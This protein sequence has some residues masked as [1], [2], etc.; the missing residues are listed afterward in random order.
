VEVLRSTA[1][2]RE[3]IE[4]KERT[5]ELHDAI[6]QGFQSYG[7]QTFDQSLMFLVRSNLVTFEEARRHATNP[8]DFSLRYSGISALSDARWDDFETSELEV[9]PEFATSPSRPLGGDQGAPTS[10]GMRSAAEAA[11]PRTDRSKPF[12]DEDFIERN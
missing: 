8:D 11:T 1:R 7:M 2:V 6:A 3:L 9:M 12:E 10:T 5:K 4:D